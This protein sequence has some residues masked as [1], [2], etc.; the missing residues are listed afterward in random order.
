MR[1]LKLIAA[2]LA[3][4]LAIAP[5]AVSGDEADGLPEITPQPVE[6]DPGQE[7]NLDVSLRAW[8]NSTYTV[9]FQDRDRFNFTG[10]R[11]ETHAMTAGDAILFRVVCLVEEDT[12]NGDFSISF[13]VTWDDNG[14]AREMEGTVQVRV[15]EGAGTDDICTGA[16]VAA[17][18]SVLAFSLL[19][20]GT[21]RRRE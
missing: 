4:L 3:L 18:I 9:T 20:V 13:K 1:T 14:T 7:F 2:M 5:L 8:V 6:T 19:M 17:P 21:R 12:P 15:G 10:E 16:M 11:H